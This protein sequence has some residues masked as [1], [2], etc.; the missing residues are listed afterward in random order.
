[1]PTDMPVTDEALWAVAKNAARHLIEANQHHGAKRFASAVPSAVYAIEETG[2]MAYLHTWG[3]SPKSKRHATHTMLFFALLKAASSWKW[4]WEWARILRGGLT[5]D[6][7]LTEQQLRTMA[8]H[9]EYAAIV[10]QLR[11]GKLSTLEERTQAFAAAMVA[12]E[13]RD[14][15]TAEWKPR[16]EKGLQNERLRATYVDITESGFSSPEAI[17]A[18][19]ASALCWLANAMLWLILV[20]ALFGGRLKSYG[21]EIE[22]LLPDDLIGAADLARILE[23]LQ[24]AGAKSNG[25]T[26][27]TAAAT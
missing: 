8:E 14:G 9:P 3:E 1:M 27:A 13:E 20:L 25:N 21:G 17:N 19:Q 23:A 15:T 18:D 10:E 7:V 16:F 11:A 4:T 6:V 26:P 24:K 12:K 2:K 5:P 22:H